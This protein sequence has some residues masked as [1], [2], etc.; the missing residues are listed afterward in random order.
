VLLVLRLFPH[1]SQAETLVKDQA[2]QLL[3]RCGMADKLQRWNE[4][5]RAYPTAATG[6]GTVATGTGTVATGTATGAAT[7]IS[8]DGTAS[9]PPLSSIEGMDAAAMA[10]A[11]KAFYAAVFA[12]GA[13]LT[14]QCERYVI[15]SGICF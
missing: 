11:F 9:A 5:K 2:A 13:M 7:G 10:V 1:T 6:T 8:A 3:R 4:Y 15:V 12:L 14:P